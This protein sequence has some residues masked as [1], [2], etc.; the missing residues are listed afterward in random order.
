MHHRAQSNPPLPPL[1]YCNEAV[2][3]EF[4]D[5]LWFGEWNSYL[6]LKR[7]R[8]NQT[9]AHQ[10][11]TDSNQWFLAFMSYQEQRRIIHDRFESLIDMQWQLKLSGRELLRFMR[12]IVRVLTEFM[13]VLIRSL[14]LSAVFY[15]YL[16]LSCLFTLITSWLMTMLGVFPVLWLEIGGYL[17]VNDI[18][19]PAFGWVLLIVGCLYP[20]T[21][22]IILALLIL[23]P[24][25]QA[26]LV[27]TLNAIP[28]PGNINGLLKEM[29]LFLFNALVPWITRSWATITATKVGPVDKMDALKIDVENSIYRLSL[30]DEPSA[31]KK[32][33]L[34]ETL[35][36]KIEDDVQSGKLPYGAALNKAYP[37]GISTDGSNQT[38]SFWSV[39]STRRHSSQVFKVESAP[40]DSSFSFFS[41][42]TTAGALKKYVDFNPEPAAFN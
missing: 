37:I 4:N 25:F 29:P 28:E 9:I 39:A 5:S 41:Q 6:E 10:M 22:N 12:S 19:E 14:C 33:D 1:P 27:K 40:P 32:A 35:W 38:L 31:Q 18:H 15:M 26:A 23:A 21:I 2:L 3:V 34:L 8:L 7:N 30:L 17:F 42:P 20:G 16:Y 13:K 24:F 11:I 36:D